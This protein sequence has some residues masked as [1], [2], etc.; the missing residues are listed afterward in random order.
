[1]APP[2]S[3]DPPRTSE[4]FRHALS[5]LRVVHSRLA[6]SQDAPNTPCGETRIDE[7]QVLSRTVT[8][9]QDEA[10]TI[11]GRWQDDVARLERELAEAKAA[12]AH[13]EGQGKHVVPWSAQPAMPSLAAAEPSMELFRELERVEIV[14]LHERQRTAALIEEK[15]ASDE[16]H[17][18]D[19]GALEE[20]LMQVMEDN[21]DLKSQNARLSAL[22]AAEM[23]AC[24]VKPDML[25]QSS[26]GSPGLQS[27]AEPEMECSTR[28]LDL[29]RYGIH[30][31]TNP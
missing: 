27:E 6:I 11:R 14:L 19:V 1:M 20:M 8:E 29:D 26:P 22:I 10:K 24:N 3:E 9:L 15:D 7:C 30:S 2:S 18:R 17:A 28:S 5:Q 31:S 4:D 21:Q 16:S 23:L 12:T 13:A 25:G